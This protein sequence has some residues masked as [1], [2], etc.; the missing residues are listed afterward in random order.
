MTAKK[1]RT[2]FRASAEFFVTCA[3]Y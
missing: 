3:T 1:C 2:G